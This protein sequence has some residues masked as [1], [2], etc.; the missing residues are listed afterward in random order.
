[1]DEKTQPKSDSETTES[2]PCCG[3]QAPKPKDLSKYDY[4]N[5]EHGQEATRRKGCC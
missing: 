3:T 5:K 4:R 2:K 1:M